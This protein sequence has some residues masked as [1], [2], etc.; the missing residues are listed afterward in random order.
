MRNNKTATA[1]FI[2]TIFL[3]L[4][5]CHVYAQNETRQKINFN[6]DWLFI[7]LDSVDRF[8]P[9]KNDSKS[10]YDTT[11]TDFASQFLN[12]YIQSEGA[13]ASEL[14]KKEVDF[15]ITSFNKEYSKLTSKQWINVVLPHTAIVEPIVNSQPSW[16]G[17][18]YYRKSFT[19][20]T[21]WKGKKLFLEF[22]GAMQ[23][24]DVWINGR[25]V[26]QHKGG[27]TPFSLDITDI[28]T[29]DK[30]NEIIVRL[31][32]YPD[33]N[34]PVGKDLNRNGFTYWSGIYRSVFLHITN[35]VHITDAVKANQT[36]GGGVFFRTPE[37]SKNL[38]RALVKTNI[39]NQSNSN[40]RVKV[41]QILLNGSEEIVINNFSDEIVLNKN[42]DSNISQQFEIKNPLLWNPDNPNL[43]TLKTIVYANDKKVDEIE[44][45]VGLRKLSFSRKEGFKINDES[46]YL[47]G[48]NL[49]QD[50]PFLGVAISK[51]AHYRDLKK[52]KEAGYN[53]IRL[54]HYPHDPSVYEAADELGLML[55]NT[56]PGWQFFNNN[57][58]F[59]QRVYRDIR[60]MI[61]RD[62]NHASVI[63]WE[64]NVNEGYPPDSFRQYCHFLAHEELPV[65]EYFTAGETYGAKQ[66]NWDVAINNWI[67]SSD[68]IFRNVEERVQNVQPKTAGIIKEYADWEFG[69]WNSTT[70]SSRASG[71]KTMLQ[72]LW[73]TM[74]EYN[75]N[76]ANYSPYTVGA[77]TWAM[78]DN[79]ISG[80][81]KLYEWGTAD[82]FRLPK[83]T[84]YLF[85]TQLEPNKKIAGIENNKPIV[86]I[87][88][89]WTP[90]NGKNKVI[91]FSNCDKIVLKVN[92]KIVGE[93]E[94]DNGPNTF[95][96]V[97]EKGG[98][99]FDGGNC[100]SLKH[101]PFT[102]NNIAFEPGELKAEGYIN[103][104]KIA[105]HIVITPEKPVS[106]SLTA[107]LSGRPLKADGADAVF[108]H[109][110]IID[111]NQ[112]ISC[113]DNT[114]EVEFY[115]IGD[116]KILG[117]SKT[118]T[119]GGIASILLQ[120]TS[121]NP[122]KVEILAKVKGLKDEVLILS[123][124]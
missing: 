82:Y 16:E 99:P 12:E 74:W 52:I 57:D 114:T 43:Y 84:G 105:E 9:L 18:C 29:F 80:D 66:T 60:D 98:N 64:P 4:V 32:N 117:P 97:S 83:F 28:I 46:L 78:Y 13:A 101:P 55:L 42:S 107:D 56:I 68:S 24:S 2:M 22:E 33:K 95:Y 109:A 30:S 58:I 85:R 77:C 120:S 90:R 63:L 38:A 54:A 14:I 21:D 26:L 122:G 19:P 39:I 115:V 27:Y 87:A 118:N 8:A 69:A 37:V 119:R 31:D 81:N 36:A 50:Y 7:R 76:I 35:P 15:A 124:K 59:K 121:L 79:Y 34:F 113:L 65:G 86:L 49:H 73:N 116:A 6:N 123:S 100:R 94:P 111:K 20:K 44:Q 112:T 17:V 11:R 67:G 106:I 23:Q 110:S 93:Q 1:F 61:H 45:R 40:T 51:D 102:F 103:G 47:V 91:V 10:L 104:T 92:N 72:G 48:T 3:L 88:N 62:R 89:W 53:T 108:I 71:E 25:L 41:Q 75:S 96:G 5:N 70:R